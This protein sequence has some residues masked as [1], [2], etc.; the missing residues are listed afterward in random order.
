M[1]MCILTRDVCT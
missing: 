1:D